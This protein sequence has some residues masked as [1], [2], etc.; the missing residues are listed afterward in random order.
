[1]QAMLDFFYT[2]AYEAPEGSSK[3]MFHLKVHALA[4]YYNAG[5]L[6]SASEQRLKKACYREWEIED[7]IHAVRHFENEERKGMEGHAELK[8]FLLKT[9]ADNFA[10]LSESEEFLQMLSE[11]PAFNGEVLKTVSHIAIC[12]QHG[13]D[14]RWHMQRELAGSL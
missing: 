12:M 11:F 1:M 7:L 5:G 9:V 4:D 8:K 6:I 2:S 3:L 10:K 13:R 14:L